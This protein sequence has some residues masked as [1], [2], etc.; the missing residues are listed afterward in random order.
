MGLCFFCFSSKVFCFYGLPTLLSLLFLLFPKVFCFCGLPKL[1]SLLF[2][3]FP[4]GFLLLWPASF[5]F[6]AFLI[7]PKVFCFSGLPAL[8]SLLF[9]VFPMVSCFQLAVVTGLANVPISR[10]IRGS[11]VAVSYSLVA[12]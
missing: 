9:N 6:V 12:L 7:F 8:L 3:A 5:A 11:L 1:L 10:T 4:E 2:V